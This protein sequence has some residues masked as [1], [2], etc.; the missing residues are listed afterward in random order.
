MFKPAWFPYGRNG[1]K[2]RVTVFL[3]SQFIIVY[4]CKPHINHTHSLVIITLRIISSKMLY[5]G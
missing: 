5:F 4:I 3:N 2:N 1:H